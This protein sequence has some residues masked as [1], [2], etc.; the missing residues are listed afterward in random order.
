MDGRG[1]GE[2]ALAEFDLLVA[3]VER[4]FFMERVDRMER[5]ADG[6]NGGKFMLAEF[7]QLPAYVETRSA[8]VVTLGLPRGVIIR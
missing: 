4:F 1:G 3:S 2:E 8:G 7:D 5:F 6:R